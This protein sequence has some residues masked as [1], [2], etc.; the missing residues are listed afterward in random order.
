MM[1]LV[2]VFV[3]IIFMVTLVKPCCG[4]ETSCMDEIEIPQGESSESQSPCDATPCSS[5]F[6]C[7][8]C[9][10]FIIAVDSSEGLHV[11]PDTDPKAS[12]VGNKTVQAGFVNGLKKPPKR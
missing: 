12:Q 8:N 2:S 1:K 10:G 9:P 6:T 4:E 5:S 3:I 11:F 7:G